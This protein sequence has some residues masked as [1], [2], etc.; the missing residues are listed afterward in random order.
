MKYYLLL[1]LV[2][3]LCASL[4]AQRVSPIQSYNLRNLI[5]SKVGNK[6]V[7]NGTKVKF[8]PIHQTRYLY[9]KGEWVKN[10]EYKYSYDAKG[11]I[12]Q[13]DSLKEDTI[14]RIKYEWTS[15]GQLATKTI[16]KS[17]DRGATF[18]PISKS[19]LTYDQLFPD[20][21]LSNEKYKWNSN[22]SDWT[23]TEDSRRKEITRDDKKNVISVTI[24][25]PKNGH[26]V[27]IE[28]ITNTIDLATKKVDSFK[29]ELINEN[30]PNNP[31]WSEVQY[32][33]NLKW[34]ETNGQIAYEYGDDWMAS[35]NYVLTGTVSETDDNGGI[36][37]IGTI[38]VTYTGDGG[39]IDY[40]TDISY[41]EKN[42]HTI[43][44]VNGSYTDVCALYYDS[45][46]DDRYT[47]ADVVEYYETT[48]VKYDNFGNIILEENFDKDGKKLDGIKCDITYDSEHQNTP[49]EIVTSYWNSEQQGYIPAFKVVT[50]HFSSEATSIKSILSYV[51]KRS[52]IYNINGIKIGNT[53]PS[54]KHGVFIIRNGSKTMKVTR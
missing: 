38:N 12:L 2:L 31:Y 17:H 41:Q 18:T 37:D 53:L 16:S 36:K 14:Y 13:M 19:I 48:Y 26:F 28:R 45:N 21:T 5:V 1:V 6:K 50:N 30:D 40:Y 25:A 33:R 7:K 44:D 52:D 24:S 11:N 4:N 51:G 54:D 27:P 39:F 46:D 32:L 34:K 42:T 49:K 20:I 29:D 47:D 35:G 22:I 8:L 43:N 9:N 15:L 10:Y 3:M 23:I